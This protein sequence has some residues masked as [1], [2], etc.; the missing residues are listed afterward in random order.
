MQKFV[1]YVILILFYS[2]I[3][4]QDSLNTTFNGNYNN[5][6]KIEYGEK[7]L[8]FDSIASKNAAAII[9]AKY[10]ARPYRRA[11]RIDDYDKK[12]SD[13]FIQLEANSKLKTSRFEY[14]TLA[15]NEGCHIWMDKHYGKPYNV[16]MDGFRYLGIDEF[17]YYIDTLK[18]LQLLRND[19]NE[20]FDKDFVWNEE[21]NEWDWIT[22]SADFKD[23]YTGLEAQAAIWDYMKLQVKHFG[24]KYGYKTPTN[25]QLIFWSYLF[26]N[27]HHL[28]KTWK[29]KLPA[30]Q[31]L[32]NN[33]S[34]AIP[35]ARID[36][37]T[38][39]PATPESKA[40]RFMLTNLLD[41]ASLKNWK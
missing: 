20:G 26:Y 39:N 6:I 36:K 18:S 23:L 27:R 19:F 34:F 32:K 8:I 29:N 16:Y 28:L 2:K 15:F 3:S 13:M 31:I 14:F 1:K 11:S 10:G 17:K 41:I 33:G 37:T 5:D 21:E 12:F 38:H 4:A 24:K 25:D 30:A 9:Q 40:Y 22:T 7:Q 35:L